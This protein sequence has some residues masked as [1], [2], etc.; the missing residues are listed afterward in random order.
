[1]MRRFIP[2]IAASI[3][4][5]GCPRPVQYSR[6][7]LP[8]P[9]AWPDKS[10]GPA[11]APA[12]A[13]LKWREFFSDQRLQSVIELAL[14]NNRDLRMATLNI[15]KVQALYRIQRAELYPTIAASAGAEGYRVPENLSGGDE[16]RTVAQYTVGLGTASWELD[17]FGRIR[18]LRSAALERYLATEQARS[19]TQ[20]SLIAAVAN[21]Y[22]ALAAD[23]EELRL[24]QVTLEAQQASYDLIRRSRDLGIASDLDLRQVQTQVDAARV[25]IARYSAQI[26]LDENALN[27]LV[28]APVASGMLS[29]NLS[30]AGAVKDI[31][32]GLPSEVLLRRPDILAAEHQL[33]AASANI[34]AARAAFFPRISLTAAAGVVSSDLTNLFKP[35]A[36]TWNLA[37]QAILPIFDSGA[38]QAAYRVAEAD[39]DMA[40]ATYEKAI[41][42]AF[43]EVSDALS[44][45]TNLM[46]Q[47][48]ALQSLV[49][50]LEETYRLSETRYKAGI[51]SYLSVLVAQRSLFAAQQQLVGIR[52]ARLSNLVTLYKVLGGGA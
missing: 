9:H 13:D 12:A 33:K 39:R 7:A 14:A 3:L 47:Q 40:I 21:T 16:A 22:L 43:R 52:L 17:F 6:P 23:R 1:M 11:G 8:V 35:A 49:N 34:G 50:S 2:L 29:D 10:P 38:R 41:Q 24:A 31:A 18:S 42:A 28:G 36:G 25:E 30:E 37:P 19:A 27:L 44:L 15:D 48:D 26:A 32:P 51:D 46:A 4:A 20:I 45:R 5:C